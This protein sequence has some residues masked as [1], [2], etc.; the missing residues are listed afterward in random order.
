MFTGKT[1]SWCQFTHF[2]ASQFSP[3]CFDSDL[4]CDCMHLLFQTHLCWVL[5]KTSVEPVFLERI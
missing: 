5:T 3:S 4:C 1:L 2:V